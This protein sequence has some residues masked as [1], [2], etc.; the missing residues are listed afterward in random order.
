MFL[1]LVGKDRKFII[2]PTQE[3]IDEALEGK[4]DLGDAIK[5]F[6]GG[7]DDSK[8]DVAAEN[9]QVEAAVESDATSTDVATSE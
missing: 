9:V 2:Q 8:A 7:S 1:Y 4:N 5:N 6:F 3:V